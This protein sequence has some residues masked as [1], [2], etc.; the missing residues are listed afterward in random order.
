MRITIEEVRTVEALTWEQMCEQDG[1]YEAVSEAAD[2]V[3]IS[4]GRP[5]FR[6][7]LRVPNDQAVPCHLVIE[8]AWVSCRF[9]RSRSSVTFQN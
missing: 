9:I 4:S 7:V 8:K 5:G 1:V 2:G 3:F 6:F